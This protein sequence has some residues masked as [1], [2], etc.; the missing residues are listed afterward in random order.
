M[1]IEFNEIKERCDDLE[2]QYSGRNE[3]LDKVEEI[4]LMDWQDKP[5]GDVKLTISPSGRNTALGAIRL[6]TSTEPKFSI[7]YEKS[8]DEARKQSEPIEKAADAM[9]YTSGRIRQC[10]IHFDV[11][12]SAVIFGEVHI[13]I[14]STKDLSAN[15]KGASKATMKRLEYI[16]QM[17]PYMFEV[18]NPK[19]GYPE[20]DG[21]GMSAY[22]RKTK[23]KTGEVLDRWGKKAQELGLDPG[24]RFDD[25]DYCDY[26]DNEIHV[27]W[28]DG[29]GGYL[30]MAEHKLP[31]I[32][33]VAQIVDGS[34]IH[35]DMEYQR[36][37]FLYTLQ[38]SGL[39]ERQNLSLT[40]MYSLVNWLGNNP[41]F[42]F[43]GLNPDS[44]V[45]FDNTVPGGIVKI[46]AGE[47]FGPMAKNI[48][49]PSLMQS[50]EIAD[51][52]AMES[53]MY[54]QALGQPMASGTAYSTVALLNQAGRLPLTTIQRRASWGI[55]RAMEIAMMLLKDG[56]GKASMKSKTGELELKAADIPDKL[57]FDVSL[58]IDMPQDE[59]SNAEVAIKLSSGEDPIA[60]KRYT[61]EKIMGIEQSEDMEREIA[62]ER[63]LKAILA[64]Q[65][66]ALIQKA[67]MA[68][69]P[70]PPPGM[71]PQDQM[72]S[73]PPPGAMGQPPPG[74]EQG[75][76][77]GMEQG[78]P[79]GMTPEMMQQMMMEQGGQQGVEP[80]LPLNEPLP[81]RGQM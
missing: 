51:R 77:P 73:R 21:L 49:D 80:G 7:P 29:K 66:N 15:A 81:P 1:A 4:F 31:C 10:P 55:G 24:Q 12:S 39:W 40:V 36:Q 45:Q 34:T 5:T 37:P 57:L 26:W 8:N 28:I 67:Q 48:L 69:Q 79:P 19:M 63:F 11:V 17:T 75:P 27:A 2:A 53:T 6:L 62:M 54:Q 18:F 30:M 78:L 9:W 32:P 22:Y 3:M 65:T 33:I 72:V 20:Y 42:I 23:V 13:G 59:R 52:L 50:M 76:P 47:D 35:S 60:S 61:R 14:T 44:D 16:E 70:Q 58:E 74:M 68:G 56:G 25:V 64:G 46:L 41:Q 38:K 43:K 71:P